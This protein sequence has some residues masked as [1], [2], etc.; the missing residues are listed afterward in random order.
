MTFGIAIPI[1]VS[2]LIGTP[3][4][5]VVGAEEAMIVPGTGDPYCGDS[6]SISSKK[7]PGDGMKKSLAMAAD[8][9]SVSGSATEPEDE[10]TGPGREGEEYAIQIGSFPTKRDAERLSRKFSS[11]GYQADIYANFPDGKTL[12][13]LVW[14][15]S[16]RSR[17]EA[18]EE[19]R[20]IKK[21]F[22]ID[23]VLTT[24]AAWKS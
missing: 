14:V 8:S 5:S 11:V 3:C 23:G 7:L 19:I 10:V 4:S 22:N 12:I 18:K 17:E 20:T 24:R 9:S 2:I 16:Y 13:Y 15:G 21:R 1:I 6:T